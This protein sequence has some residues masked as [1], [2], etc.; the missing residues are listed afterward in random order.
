MFID[1]SSYCQKCVS[2]N[3]KLFQWL[4]QNSTFDFLRMSPPMSPISPELKERILNEQIGSQVD[5]DLEGD[6]VTQTTFGVGGEVEIER[7]PRN[8][9]AARVSK[10]HFK[11]KSISIQLYYPNPLGNR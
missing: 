8:I 4:A 1:F 2:A 5:D 6:Q 9:Y 3:T 7:T 10:S 11:I